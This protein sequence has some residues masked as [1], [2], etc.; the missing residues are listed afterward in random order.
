MDHP[1][2]EKRGND[3][4]KTL[5]EWL[6]RFGSR[7]QTGFI[8]TDPAKGD[9]SVVYVNNAFSEMTGYTADEVYGKNLRFMHGEETDKEL[10]KEIDEKLQAGAPANA[11]ILHYKKDGTPFWNELVIQPL[12]NAQGLI[13][14]T[15]SFMLD[16]TE[17]KKDEALLKLQEQIFAGINAGETLHT[18]LQNICNVVE[19]F[20]P[21]GT[22]S[23]ILFKEPDGKWVVGVA[24]SVPQAFLEEMLRNAA[25]IKEEIPEEWLIIEDV[26]ENAEWITQVNNGQNFKYHACWSVPIQDSEGNLNGV[27]TVCLTKSGRPTATQMRFLEKLPQLILLAKSYDEQQE[28]YRILA[29][30]DPETGLPNRHAFIK[31]LKT[32]AKMAKAY[33]VAIVQPGEFSKIVDLYGR[34]AADELFI[35]LGKRIELAGEEK[36]NFVGRFSSSSLILT[37]EVRAGQK[38]HHMLKLNKV[39]S[40]PFV[41]AGEEMFLTLKIGVALSTANWESEEELLR[42]ADIA[43][44]NA[45]KQAG[46]AMI[47]Y[48]DLQNEETVQEMTIF[49][50]LSR[51]LATCEIDVYL[52]PQVSLLDEKITGFE[53][54]ARWTSPVLGHVPPDLFIPAAESTGKIIELENIVLSKV[55]KWQQGRM[56][57]GKKLYQVA[58]NISVH[59]FFHPEFITV[60]KNLVNNYGLS[61]NYIKL[62]MTES[63]GLVDFVQAKKVFT[64][65]SEA[66]FELSVD[67]FGVGYSSLNYLTQ[68]PVDELKIDRSFIRRLDDPK[69]CAVIRTIVQ[70]AENLN[71]SV[72]A[73]GIEEQQHIEVLQNLGCHMGQGY[74]YDKP[75]P[76]DEIDRLLGK[77]ENV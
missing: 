62:E 57:A 53:A 33:F 59:H 63:I 39:V 69:T 46:N 18:S 35:Q 7:F 77:R 34:G 9:D 43:M 67:D 70:L 74:Y 76:L 24:Q 14:F 40:E 20:F 28:Q 8:V 6:K 17:K 54:L 61:P 3:E 1:H 66:G 23:S 68:L 50:E 15:A 44:T 47:F 49:N 65:L 21:A 19:S 4:K 36:P 30:T 51:A 38:G 58:V 37:N 52:Q 64:E 55:L 25:T 26:S 42:R 29:F 2:E 45:K 13:L 32:D 73:E 41:V 60:L 48:K 5:I 31:K 16:V 75:M 56:R 11:E 22:I 10:I 71:L 12:V 72:V 27:F